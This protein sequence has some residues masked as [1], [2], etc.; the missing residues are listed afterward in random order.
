MD[1][2]VVVTVVIVQITRLAA[3]VVLMKVKDTQQ[4]NHQDHAEHHPSHSFFY[5]RRA[6]NAIEAVG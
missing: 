6:G 4:E 5:N 1:D 3:E 2:T